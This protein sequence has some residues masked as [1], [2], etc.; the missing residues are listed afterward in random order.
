MRGLVGGVS[1]TSYM[2]T[3]TV[4]SA[5]K[6]YS[7]GAGARWGAFDTH[8]SAG[9]SDAFSRFNRPL[10]RAVLELVGPFIIPEQVTAQSDKVYGRSRPYR[11]VMVLIGFAETHHNHRA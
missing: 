11:Y 8:L 3:G 1:L 4:R 2:A 10:L 7:M 9:A 5:T 6:T